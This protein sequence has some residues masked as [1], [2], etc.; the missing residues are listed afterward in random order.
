M[1]ALVSGV[2][3]GLAIIT[4]FAGLLMLAAWLKPYFLAVPTGLRIAMT[5]CGA[6]AAAWVS[7]ALYPGARS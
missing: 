7:R 5:L 3:A 4:F 2:F 6:L 1:K